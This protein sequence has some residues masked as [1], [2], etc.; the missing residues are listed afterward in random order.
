MGNGFQFID[1][2]LFAMIAAFLIL[3][4]RSVL[5][6]RDGH[7]GNYRDPFKPDPADS[8]D[9]PEAGDEA[10]MDNVV[11]MPGRDDTEYDD[12]DAGEEILNEVADDPLSIGM[13]QIVRADPGFDTEDF[14]VGGRVAFEMVLGAY[15]SGDRETLKNLLSPG[16]LDNFLHAI[17]DRESAGYVMED[18]LVGIRSADI[19]EAF[20][21]GGVSNITV[22]FV[23]E[24]VNVTRD[25]QGHVI[26]GSPN[27]V[28]D[29]VDFW[30]FERDSR[31]SD[32]NWSL[33]ATRSL[34]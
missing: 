8:S 25:D 1:I 20:M 16:V 2:I 3:R 13:M 29:V 7:E 19:V 11:Q 32:P 21:E 15:A 4:L 22:K 31:S 34:D 17:D 14:L 23:S 26:D 28:T 10:G 24:Q 6:R 30:T 12:L 18:T 9:P 5:G 33:V 27:Q